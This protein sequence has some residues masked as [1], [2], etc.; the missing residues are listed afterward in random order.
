MRR[1]LRRRELL[2]LTAA[3]GGTLLLPVCVQAP[4][5]GPSTTAA[6]AD[7]PGTAGS[8]VLGKL[9]GAE[10]VLEASK[11]PKTFKEAP[12][13]A[14]LVQQGKLPPVAERIGQDPLVIKPVHGIGKY[15]GVIRKA[16]IGASDGT[17]FRFAAG[18]DSL[19][20]VDWQW[21]KVVPNIARSFE[22]SSDGRVLT[23]QLR[24]GMRWSDGA[25]FTADD[26]I[27]WYEDIYQ[28]RQLVAAPSADLLIN[29]K[30]VVIQK[31]DQH[32]IRFVSPD[33][34]YLLPQRL[35]AGGDLGGQSSGGDRGLG[36]M[37]PKH[38]LT[39]FHTK[40]TPQAEI[41][42]LVAEGKFSGWAT[43]FK[44]KSSWTLNVD[45]PVLSPWRTT[46]AMSDPNSF[47]MER[48]PYSIWVDTE[49][50][51]LPYVGTI[52]HTFA[53]DLEVISL[54]AVSGEYD[55][56]D[57]VLDVAKLPILVDAQQRGGYKIHLDPEQGGLGIAFNLAYDADTEIGDLIRNVEFRRALSIAIDRDQINE[58]FFLRTGTPGAA[59]PADD[60][61]YSPGKEWRT[62]WATLDVAQAN[63]LLDRIG[64]TQKDADGLRLRK[65]GKGPVRLEFLAVNR[66]ADFPQI[67]EVIKRQWRTIGVDLLVETTNATLAQ[68][69]IMANTAQMTGNNLGSE[70][71][72]LFSDIVIPG[73]RG[74]SAIMGTP[75]ANW[76][77]TG[78]AQGKEPFPALKQLMELWAKGYAS[79]EKERIDI[80]KEINRQF[81]DQVFGIG[82]IGQ[83]LTSYGVRY[84]KT[85]LG[86]VPGRIVNAITVRT[87]MNAH[88]MTF[89]YK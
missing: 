85:S 31:I 51:Q 30:P 25:P 15:G 4:A 69:R 34:N 66:L 12:E 59:V 7:S 32:G 24:R 84:A 79:P 62:K 77:R 71:V 65:D 89:F 1:Q 9:E 49:G 72:F 26:I 53:S 82:L 35:A 81:V 39:K 50:N 36:L 17:A 2:K 76:M 38:Y 28:N 3:A 44:N 60:N 40:Y 5:T 10:V 23:V 45:L 16:F 19:V 61:K 29:G 56:Q 43:F 63:Q 80:G 33:P 14:A 87:S 67:A 6:P 42:R 83:G 57:R 18:P 27:F 70:D 8:F 13:L 78:G 52:S 75:Y 22:L 48:N 74:F 55:F 64:Y 86:N 73:G 47:V 37:A 68:A 20:Y 11:F 46:R 21:T 54:R 41:D 58:T 88:P